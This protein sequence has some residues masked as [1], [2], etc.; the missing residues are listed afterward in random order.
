MRVQLYVKNKIFYVTCCPDSLW[1]VYTVCFVTLA[2]FMN[3]V[4]LQV[5]LMKLLVSS[6]DVVKQYLAR[7]YNAFASMCTG[8]YCICHKVVF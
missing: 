5:K 8:M 6:S 2:T 4:H 3:I 7:L 1:N